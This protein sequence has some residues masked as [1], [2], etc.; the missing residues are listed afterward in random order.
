MAQVLSEKEDAT[1]TRLQGTA[2][3][4]RGV[5]EGR[6][7]AFLRGNVVQIQQNCYEGEGASPGMVLRV[8][9]AAVPVVQERLVWYIGLHAATFVYRKGD[10]RLPSRAQEQHGW[11]VR[12][13]NLWVKARTNQTLK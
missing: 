10:A 7:S 12:P 11:E 2:L 5:S 4:S 6:G 13:K 8:P 3:A 1:G 9:E